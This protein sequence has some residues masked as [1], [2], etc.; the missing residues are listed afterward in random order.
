MSISLPV[1][2]ETISSI[3]SVHGRGILPFPITP[4]SNRNITEYN[5]TSGVLHSGSEDEHI[6]LLYYAVGGGAAGSLL[7]LILSGIIIACVRKR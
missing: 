1:H 6:H 4:E 5:I 2:V 3:L 7:I